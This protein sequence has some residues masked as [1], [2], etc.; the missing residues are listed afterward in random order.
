MK[1]IIINLL[2]EFIVVNWGAAKFEQIFERCPIEAQLP[3]VGPNTYPDG[4]L[5][6]IVDQTCLELGVGKAEALRSFG[7]FLFPRLADRFSIFVR[8][9]QHPKSFLKTVHGIIHIEV[10]KVYAHAEPPLITFSDPGPDQLVMSYTSRRKL[11][12]LFAGLVEGTGDY[13]KVPL[14][15]AQTQCT[16]EGAPS[17]EFSLHFPT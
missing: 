5:L 12:A 13:F 15:L 3:Y 17:C 6:A 2:E 4:H 16:L 1:G 10:Q 8:E 7:R 14:A 11:C 9:H